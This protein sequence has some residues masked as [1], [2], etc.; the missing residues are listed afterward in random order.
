M[1]YLIFLLFPIFSFGQVSIDVDTSMT[2]GRFGAADT[3]LRVTIVKYDRFY[4]EDSTVTWL[5]TVIVYQD[6]I[7]NQREYVWEGFVSQKGTDP[8]LVYL[9]R[10]TYPEDFTYEYRGTGSIRFTSAN[11]YFY[12]NKTY[13]IIS[14]PFDQTNA[15]DTILWFRDADNYLYLNTF[16][17]GTLTDDVM[18][19]T[20]VKIVTIK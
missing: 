16:R 1:R 18:S 14:N 17:A 2:T 6:S 3:S 5:D 8:P 15:Y 9:I 4:N 7:T 20:Y 10:N 13:V 11:S 12:E 19:R